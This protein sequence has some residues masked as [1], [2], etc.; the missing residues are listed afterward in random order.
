MA[1]TFSEMLY[2]KMNIRGVMQADLCRG[3][4]S[5]TAMSRY[6]QGER[7]IDRMLLTAFM[8]RLGMSPDKFTTL[9]TQAEYNYFEWK[10]E[11]VLAQIYGD[12]EKVEC[13][14]QDGM[15]ADRKCNELLQ[16]QFYLMFKGIVAGKIYGDDDT[17]IKL[18][19]AAV[20]LTIP[21]FPNNLGKNTLFCIQELNA[22][23]LWLELQQDESEK[24]ELYEY[25]ISYALRNYKDELE[26]VKIYPRLAAGYLEL[27]YHKKRYY[28]CI[29]VSEKVFELMFSTGYVMCLGKILDINIKSYKA[30]GDEEKAVKKESQLAAWNELIEEEKNVGIGDSDDIFIMDVW[31]EMELINELVRNERRKK[32]YSQEYVSEGICTPETLSRIESGNRLPNSSKYKLIMEKLSLRQEYY[33]SDIET[34]DYSTLEEKSKL[35]KMVMCELWNEAE[36]KLHELEKALNLDVAG[37]RQYIQKMKYIIENANGEIAPGSQMKMLRQILSVTVN[38]IPEGDNV[39]EWE[40]TFWLND[41]N[42]SEVSI[43]IQIADALIKNKKYER[44]AYILERVFDGCKRSRIKPEFHYRTSILIISRLSGLYGRLGDYEKEK[45]YS[46]ECIRIS[47]ISCNRNSLPAYINNLADAYEKMGDI[48]KAVKYY[49]IAYWCAE[50]FGKKYAGIIKASYDNIKN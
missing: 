13:L 42:N 36:E 43:I 31:Q 19:D 48:A 10:Q 25:L 11:V 5:T 41:F 24:L 14:L 37:N 12:Y 7:R 45:N 4:C 18:F 2:E 27:L 8:Q 28:E 39:E 33:F 29:T 1:K 16:E 32:G 26:L 47:S 50:L 21:E 30:C 35:D 3:L 49:R 34:S 44:A 9:I 46:L 20:K 38:N 22:I 15:A 23:I 40:D 17:C 6:L